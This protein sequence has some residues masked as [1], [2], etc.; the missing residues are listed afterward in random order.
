MPSPPNV[1]IAEQLQNI[2][3]NLCNCAVS[4]YA[5]VSVDP[6]VH[7]PFCAFR[8]ASL[9]VDVRAKPQRTPIVSGLC[10]D[11]ACDCRRVFGVD[12]GIPCDP[13]ATVL[14]ECLYCEEVIETSTGQEGKEEMGEADWERLMFGDWAC[15][16]CS[17][18]RA[19]LI[20]EER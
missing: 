6:E 5:P 4:R 16:K 2:A 11:P 12:P 3:K 9:V 18:S 19:D 10:D 13:D 7:A 14:T 15:P 20:G 17:E 1:G 8:V